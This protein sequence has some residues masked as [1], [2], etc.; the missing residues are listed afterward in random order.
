MKDINNIDYETYT[1]RSI[2]PNVVFGLQLRKE[3][4][5]KY[6]EGKFAPTFEQFLIYNI[7]H[8]N[9]LNQYVAPKHNTESVRHRVLFS[10]FEGNS[11]IKT[12]HKYDTVYERVRTLRVLLASFNKTKCYTSYWHYKKLTE[13]FEPFPILCN[14]NIL[15]LLVLDLKDIEE[16][17]WQT[18]D[19]HE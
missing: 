1:Y 12:W 9:R 11:Y 6:K 16:Y 17:M 14:T 13:L 8:N 3:W 15:P 5:E 18:K 2:K 10:A 19:T 4:K 7:A